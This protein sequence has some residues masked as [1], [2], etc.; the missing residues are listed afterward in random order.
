MNFHWNK[1]ISWCIRSTAAVAHTVVLPPCIYG[2]WLFFRSEC[3]LCVHVWVPTVCLRL[4]FTE[5]NMLCCLLYIYTQYLAKKKKKTLNFF[6]IFPCYNQKV[7]LGISLVFFVIHQHMLVYNLWSRDRKYSDKGARF[8]FVFNPCGWIRRMTSVL[9]LQIFRH[10][11]TE[12][13]T[14]CL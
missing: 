13:R 2:A 7:L 6:H 4:T 8:A 14:F 1:R 10:L 9:L 5:F 12:V 3:L 11:Q